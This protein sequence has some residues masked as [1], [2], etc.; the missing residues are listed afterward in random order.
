MSDN[1]QI[2]TEGGTARLVRSH[3]RDEADYIQFT[4]N[5][6]QSITLLTEH[7]EEACRAITRLLARG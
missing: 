5:D 4:D 7:A 3:R 6:G 2:R 1:S